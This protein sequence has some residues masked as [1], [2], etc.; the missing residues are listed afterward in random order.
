MDGAFGTY[1][2]NEKYVRNYS[3]KFEWSLG[4]VIVPDGPGTRDQLGS[5]APYPFT[6]I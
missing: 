1:V 6:T 2:G 5:P 3:Q 4:N